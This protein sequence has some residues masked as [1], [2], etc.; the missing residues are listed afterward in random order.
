MTA[1]FKQYPQGRKEL[2]DMIDH[3]RLPVL[4]FWGD[5]DVILKAENAHQLYSRLP[6]CAL[7]IFKDCGHFS[8]QDQS[9]AF[10]TLIQNWVR[11]KWRG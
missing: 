10:A 9:A 4:V 8:Y 6:D 7:H 1:F 3:V 5:E 2:T 11:G